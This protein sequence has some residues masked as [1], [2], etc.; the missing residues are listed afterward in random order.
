M[1]EYRLPD[2]LGHMR[3][4][5]T[6][7]RNFVDGIKKEDFLA[8]KRTQQAVIMSLVIIGEVATK[9]MDR[10]PEFADRHPTIPWRSIRGMRN[11]IAHGYFD[12]NLEVVWDT[13]ETA[14]PDLLG[15]LSGIDAK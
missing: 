5:A 6:N 1:N 2:Y 13:V 10:F 12:I 4:A 15:T 3:E 7:A 8:D 14:L 9:I 11:R